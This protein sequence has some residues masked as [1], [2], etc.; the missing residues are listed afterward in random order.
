MGK[1]CTDTVDAGVC[2]MKTIIHAVQGDD[3][4][5]TLDVKSDCPN[6]LRMSWKFKPVNPY[7]EVESPI[8]ETDI[9]KWANDVLPHA[10]CPVPSALVKAVE[11]ASE[12]GIKRGVRIDIE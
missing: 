3:L 1:E 4:M 12:L 9:Y 8:C 6:V 5:V 11:A 2:K 7:T 10:A